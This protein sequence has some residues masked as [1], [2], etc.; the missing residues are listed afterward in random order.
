MDTVSL[1]RF[2]AAFG[3]VLGLIALM[4]WALKRWPVL[5][6]AQV[7]RA[8]TR[9]RVVEQRGID[10]KHKLVLVQ[11]DDVQ[12]LLLISAGSAPV[13]V[14]TLIDATAETKQGEERGA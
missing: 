10:T 6:G 7:G 13:V 12:H 2:L 9:L 14:E 8:D 3:A 5:R 4:A 1:F 11:R